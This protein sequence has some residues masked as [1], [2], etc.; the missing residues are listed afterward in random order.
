MFGRIRVKGREK[1]RSGFFINQAPK[2]PVSFDGFN[3]I[4]AFTPT[5]PFYTFGC[6]KNL[7]GRYYFAAMGKAI[8]D[9]DPAIYKFNPFTNIIENV[10]RIRVGVIPLNADTHR[11]PNM[12]VDS[13]GN[14]YVVMEKLS[15]TEGHGSD[16]LLYKTSTPYDL[17]TLTLIKTLTGR[18]SYPFI[19]VSGTNVFICARGT[20]STIN[21]IRGQQ[22]YFNSTDNGANFGSAVQLYASGDEQKVS[23]MWAQHDYNGNICI[24]L[25]E[26]DNDTA[27][28]PYISLIRGTF[29]SNVWT[30]AGATVSKNVSSSGAFTRTEMMTNNL[31]CI[32]TDLVNISNNHEGGVIKSDGTIKVLMSVQTLTG[33]VYE[34]NSESELEELRL[35]TF[36]GGAWTFENVSIPTGMVFY[37]AYQRYMLY[38][39]NDDTTDDILFIDS[40]NDNDVYL[41]RSTDNFATETSRLQLVGNTRYRLGAIAFNVSTL[42]DYLFILTDTQGDLFEITAET[43]LDYSNIVVF[44]N[45][46][47]PS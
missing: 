33:N 46:V 3:S 28:T 12:D 23:Y 13:S 19:K 34:G 8:N 4:S 20:T 35:Y 17:S 38:I 6:V 18:W 40:L 22:W 14:L 43:A 9:R 31:V 41:K 11:L 24:I 25:N 1:R 27:N 26:R 32:T 42:D 44:H 47:A 21:F 2:A 36:A 15:A 37:W 39:N 16:I 10:V 45:I 7:D 29:N 5:S 30:N